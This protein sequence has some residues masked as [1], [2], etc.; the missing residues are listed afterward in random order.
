M[1]RLRITPIDNEQVDINAIKELDGVIGV[2]EAET[3][4][5]ILGTGV[6]NQ[7]SSAFE[8]LLNASGSYDL[9]NE[10]QKNK[11]AISQK[12]RTPFKLFL[13]RI[14][15][16]FI[17]IIPALVASGLITGI[18]KAIVQA[19]WLDEK[20]QAAI[21]LTVI[22]SGLFAYLGILVGTNA[23]KEFGG[24]P[25]LGALA[26]ILI[27]N[28][29]SADIMLFGTNILPGRGGLIGVLLAAIFYGTCGNKNQTLCPA[30]T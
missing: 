6:V 25:A 30:I 12:N 27:I 5:I 17:P 19:G 18:T 2:V 23:A 21:I 10:A 22:G 3:L 8:Q 11:Q 15:S 28:P 9:N 16:I 20:S 13:R 1:T 14:A 7:V 26:G 24:S 29:A 4:Q